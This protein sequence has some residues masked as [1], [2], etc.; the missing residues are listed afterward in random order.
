MSS[1]RRGE[2]MGREG[3]QESKRSKRRKWGKQALL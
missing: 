2:G 1:W 3:E